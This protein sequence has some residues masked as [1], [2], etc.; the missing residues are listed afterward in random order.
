[1]GAPAAGKSS[2]K[3][4]LAH[5]ESK[6][7]HTSTPV[8]E[9]PDIVS[10]STEQFTVQE[11]SSSWKTVSEE[12]V[13]ASVRIACRD[14]LYHDSGSATPPSPVH[15]ESKEEQQADSD[16]EDFSFEEDT[17]DEEDEEDTEDE[18]DEEEVRD[19]I[20]QGDILQLGLSLK[21]AHS[22][23]LH[24][25]GTGIE[26]HLLKNARFI[27]LL[28]T[29]GQPSFQDVLPLVLYVPCTYVLVFNASLD[30]DQPLPITYRPDDATEEVQSATETGWEMLL[31]L[32]SSVQTM[33]DKCSSGLDELQEQGGQLPQLRI[34]L[35]GTFKDCLLEEKRLQ[36][37]I[38][39]ITRH[40]K[41]LEKKP[42]YKHIVRD[43]TGQ[44]FFL[45]NNMMY[46]DSVG[47]T[48]EDQAHMQDLRQKLSD[49][50]G[51]LKLQVPLGWFHFQLVTNSVPQKFCKTSDLQQCALQ[52]KCV[53]STSEFQSLLTLF[54]NLGFFTFFN[55]EE[56][57][58]IVCTDN[59]AFLKE[60]SKLLAVQFVR[61]PKSRAVEEFKEKGLLSLDEVLTSELGLSK[62]LNTAWLSRSLCH[63]GVMACTSPSRYFMPAALRTEAIQEVVGTVA[64]LLVAFSFKVDEFSE[65]RDLPRGIFCCLAVELTKPKHGWLVIPEDSTRLVIRFQ[66]QDLDIAIIE[67]PGF[68]S[69]VPVL[70]TYVDCNA[71]KLHDLC[72]AVRFTI[73]QAIQESAKAVFDDQFAEQADVIYGVQ[74]PCIPS[75]HLAV[76]RGSTIS[77]TLTQKRHRFLQRQRVWFSPVEGAKVSVCMAYTFLLFKLFYKIAVKQ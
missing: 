39:N 65:S 9:T 4:L 63:L 47:S 61:S 34:F 19:N 31:R 54:H 43:A 8:M 73:E 52:L 50:A 25:L 13:A 33:A 67:M 75:L 64:P 77:C 26:D 45:I 38:K 70:S 10:I 53:N 46:S 24:N 58:N 49:P 66:W 41:Q 42:Y 14:H 23:L 71:S 16:D 3:H 32:L 60:V 44:R 74:C 37:A 17:E 48:E 22:A 35:V 27:H 18:K 68:I 15:S 2:L 76:P 12:D 29:G 1:M 28:D 20:K 30:L 55:R 51:S 59:T 69:I 57:S 56:I 11:A 72:C 7:I 36:E 21:N 5:N 62:E 6:A 40:M